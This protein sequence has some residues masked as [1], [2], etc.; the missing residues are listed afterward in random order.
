MYIKRILRGFD[1]TDQ[2]LGADVI[3]AVGPGGNFLA[4]AHTVKHFRRELWL[5]GPAWT[6][7]AWDDWQ[8]QGSQS[9]AD[10]ATEHIKT[11]L[12]EHQADPIDEDLAHEI[13]RIVACAKKELLV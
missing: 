8:D 5:S 7:Q 3:H 1:V 6:R 9:F 4:E 11:I 12:V 2:T 10:R 13:D